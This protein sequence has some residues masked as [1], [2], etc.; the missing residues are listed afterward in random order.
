MC[1]ISSAACE[2][3]LG[4]DDPTTLVPGAGVVDAA[5]ASTEASDG[6]VADA[7][8]AVDAP[9]GE[10]LDAPG[11]V[12]AGDAGI[13][14]PSAPCSAQGT[15]LFCQDFDSVDAAGAGWGYTYIGGDAGTFAL[16]GLLSTSPPNSAQ[17]VAHDVVGE[18]QLGQKGIGPVTSWIHLAFDVRIESEPSGGP[19]VGLGQLGFGSASTSIQLQTQANG[20]LSVTST[21]WA[22]VDLPALAPQTWTRI[23]LA[24]DVNAGLSISMGGAV[25]ATLP[26]TGTSIG[27]VYAIVGAVYVKPPGAP[28]VTFEIDNVVVRGQ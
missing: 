2:N 9:D 6:G 7:T 20:Q 26:A 3:L 25:V 23:V 18:V 12:D 17:F 28:Q 21:L 13:V 8:A 22:D 1:A 15:T 4:L 27:F 10:T 19:T 14:E 5:E 11:P 16:D 24:Y